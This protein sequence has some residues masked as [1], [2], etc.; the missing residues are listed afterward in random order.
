VKPPA[1]GIPDTTIDAASRIL[2]CS[3]IVDKRS[4]VHRY[5]WAILSHLLLSA[6]RK[7]RR[8]AAPRTYLQNSH[9]MPSGTNKPYE[10][11]QDQHLAPILLRFYITGLKTLRDFK[12]GLN[13]P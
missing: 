6:D 4:D 1:S 5:E 3:G 9:N 11:D 7:E 2:S 10:A 8:N 12:L 13:T